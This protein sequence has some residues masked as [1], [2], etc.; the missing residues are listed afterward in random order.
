MPRKDKIKGELY[1]VNYAEKHAANSKRSYHKRTEELIK[2][3]PKTL[4]LRRTKNKAKTRGIVCTITEDD[5]EI[6]EFCPVLGI[7]L[8]FNKG[9]LKDDSPSM[10]RNNS[11]L[12]YITG[13]VTVMSHKANRFKTDMTKED[14]GKLYQYVFNTQE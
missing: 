11:I 2:S 10:D 6:P 1:R 13:N 3:N 4:M 12:G 9:K 7:P 8:R 5:F 14:I